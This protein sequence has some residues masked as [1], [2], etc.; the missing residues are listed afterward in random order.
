MLYDTLNHLSAY[1]AL[2]PRLALAFRFLVEA[3]FSKLPDGRIEL[4]AG[5]IRQSQFL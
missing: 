2:S 3:D 5:C 1:C 4:T